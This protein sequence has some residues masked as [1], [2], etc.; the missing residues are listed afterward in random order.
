MKAPN[1]LIRETIIRPNAVI[2]TV[3]SVNFK[4]GESHGA[5]KIIKDAKIMLDTKTIF[6][7]NFIKDLTLAIF[8]SAMYSGISFP[9]ATCKPKLLIPYSSVIRLMEVA[10]I[11]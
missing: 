4:I 11:P 8:F 10:I 2:Q 1:K 5:A 7:E 9:A 3:S 6:V